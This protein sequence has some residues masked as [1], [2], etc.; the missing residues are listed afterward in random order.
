[1]VPGLICLLTHVSVYTY[2]MGTYKWLVAATEKAGLEVEQFAIPAGT[3]SNALRPCS[4]SGARPSKTAR[5]VRAVGSSS[6]ANSSRPEAVMVMVTPASIA[7]DSA[8]PRNAILRKMIK[9]PMT[10]QTIATRLPVIMQ[11]F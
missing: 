10:P 3:K 8:S 7:C 6:R 11:G 5:S 9:Q 2:F 1:M 4:S